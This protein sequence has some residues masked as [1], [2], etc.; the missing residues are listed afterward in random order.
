L[1]ILGTS[2]QYGYKA[3]TI[4]ECQEFSV[5]ASPLHLKVWMIYPCH[6]W[7]YNIQ[8]YGKTN[9]EVQRQYSS[10]FD[11]S[12][13]VVILKGFLKVQNFILEF[14]IHLCLKYMSVP[15]ASSLVSLP[16]RSGHM[17]LS[18]WHTSPKIW[19][20]IWFAPYIY[21]CNCS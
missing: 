20:E 14:V 11:I 3:P 10:F 8:L 19:D 1:C 17:E 4:L 13:L 16:F 2:L 18:T 21:Y 9:T 5:L 6:Q 15:L 12:S 7:N